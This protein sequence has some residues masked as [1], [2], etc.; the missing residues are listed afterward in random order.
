VTGAAAALGRSGEQRVSEWY[1]ERG[2]GVLARNWRCRGGEL[3]LVVGRGRLVVFCEVKTRS[4]DRFGAPAE[5]VTAA[6]Q[7]RI[8]RLA[9]RWLAEAPGAARSIRFDVAAV[10]GGAIEVIEGAF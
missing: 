6:K 1:V 3:D 5:A 2:Y 9:A 7:A 4:S 10:M 8:R